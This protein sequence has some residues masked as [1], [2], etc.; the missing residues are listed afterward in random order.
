MALRLVTLWKERADPGVGPAEGGEGSCF[1]LLDL[2][3]GHLLN[4]KALMLPLWH[5]FCSGLSMCAWKLLAGKGHSPA[6]D[7]L[8]GDS[9]GSLLGEFYELLLLFLGELLTLLYW[10][11]ETSPAIQP[12]LQMTDS[13]PCRLIVLLKL[14]AGVLSS[15][16]SVGI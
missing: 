7:Y 10:K 8:V 5:L 11:P 4:L 16:P 1:D 2:L 13:F 9:E 15:S 12:L 6:R 3:Q 14:G